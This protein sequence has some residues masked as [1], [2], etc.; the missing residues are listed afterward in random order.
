MTT[1]D[2]EREF[3]T[4]TP[5]DLVVEIGKGS[6]EVHLVE[7]SATRVQVEGRGADQVRLEQHGG[8][9][10]VIGPRQVLGFGLG[11]TSLR[12]RIDAPAASSLK[13]RTGSA[14]LA[15]AGP[16]GSVAALTG[17]GDIR[18]E[19][20]GRA[21]HVGSGS[22]DVRVQDAGAALKVK[23]GSGDVVVDRAGA[24]LAVST[25]SGNVHVGTAL[26]SV[27]A[28]TGSGDLAIG[29]AH[30][31]VSM[32]TGTGDLTI[33]SARRGR[34]TSKAASGDVR[35]GIPPT[36]PVWTDLSTVSGQIRSELPGAG[37]PD[38][39]AD[40]VELRATTVSGDI[41]LVPA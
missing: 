22:G 37:E 4:P 41:V 30:G 24:D 9:I 29:E 36:V 28:K 5:A 26:D 3:D 35:I 23:S 39:G 27:V 1:P 20:L 14:D 33:S 19:S 17:S 8:E 38:E 18:I 31:D 11:D 13:V 7:T 21:S 16:A 15:V 40:Y 6:I 34:L 32:T 10:R 12:V 25:G 2:V